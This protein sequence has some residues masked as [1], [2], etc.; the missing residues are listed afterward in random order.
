MEPSFRNIVV[1]PVKVSVTWNGGIGDYLVQGN[2]TIKCMSPAQIKEFLISEQAAG[3]FRDIGTYD[4]YSRD[5]QG[6]VRT[7]YGAGWGIFKTKVHLEMN[8]GNESESAFHVE[9]KSHQDDVLR[10][11]GKWEMVHI[12]QSNDSAVML[13]Q[14]IRPNRLPAWIPLRKLIRSRITRALRDLQLVLLK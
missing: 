5:A 7:S 12:P 14:T 11:A 3:Y 2:A 13:T 1:S 4:S 6:T 8:V 9:F 10:V